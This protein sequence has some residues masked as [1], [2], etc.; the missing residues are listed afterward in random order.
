MAFYVK[1]KKISSW[2]EIDHNSSFWRAREKNDIFFYFQCVTKWIRFHVKSKL[3]EGQGHNVAPVVLHKFCFLQ[4][5]Q[6]RSNLHKN[7]YFQRYISYN[8]KIPAVHWQPISVFYS[9]FQSIFSLWFFSLSNDVFPNQI[10]D[11]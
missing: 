8:N 9:N 10:N 1:L 11:F 6:F 2:M 5:L 3:E 7:Q 4:I